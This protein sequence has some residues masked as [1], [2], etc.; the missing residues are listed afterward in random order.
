MT[1]KRV[2]PVEYRKQQNALAEQMRKVREHTFQISDAVYK[3]KA[4]EEVEQKVEQIKQ[5]SDELLRMYKELRG[6]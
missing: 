3:D 2:D 5:D 1:D 4:T 6:A